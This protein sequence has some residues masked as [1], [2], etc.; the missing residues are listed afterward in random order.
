[1][2]NDHFEGR[3]ALVTGASRGFG[4]ALTLALA[5]S[6]AHVIAVARH[7][8]GLE[9]LDDELRHLGREATLVPLDLSSFEGIDQLAVEVFRRWKKLD[10][11]VGNAAILGPL[12]PLHHV[13]AP[14]WQKVL[15]INLTAN[16]HLIR[17]FHS[18][19]R[20]SDAG[21]AAFVTSGVTQR[22]RGYWGAYAVAKAALEMMVTTW[23]VE[24]D[25]GTLAFNLIDPGAMRTALRASAF[26][27]EDPELLPYPEDVAPAFLKILSPQWKK[28]G[29]RIAREDV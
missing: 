20:A 17:A 26:P 5:K 3:L 19:L 14:E 10:I 22:T 15:D 25:N 6:G 11:L 28:T 24:N 9:A 18:L 12:T 2:L 27:G 29:Q 7:Q 1:M 23:A 8:K 21:R 4:R 16:F 13:S